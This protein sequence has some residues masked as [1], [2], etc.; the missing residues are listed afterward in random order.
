MFLPSVN[1]VTWL[2]L[3]TLVMTT[4]PL[5]RVFSMFVYLYARFPLSLIGGNLTAQSTESHRGIESGIQ[6]PET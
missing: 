4:L 2:D 6:I 1:K 5:E 3:L